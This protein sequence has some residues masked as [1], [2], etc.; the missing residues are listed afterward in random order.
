MSTRYKVLITGAGGM[1]GVD[2]SCELVRCYELYG[3]DVRRV[4]S[5]EYR[6]Q[7][8][9]SCDIIDRK[10]L[11]KLIGKIRPDV[12]IH[13]AAQTDVD[14]CELEPKKA[15][16]INS[17]GTKNVALACK[18]YG[19]VLIYISTDF[20]FD[21]KKRTPYKETDKPNPIS[22]Y[23]DSKLKGEEAVRKALKKFFILRTSW[24]YGKCGKN[25]VD[26]ILANAKSG[27]PLRVVDDQVGS[28][29]YTKDLA[30]AIH[31]LLNKIR[32]Q[33]T[34]YRE[35]RCGIYHISN[36]GIVSWYDYARGILK[37]VKSPA[38]IV[39]ISSEEL[40]RPARRPAMSVLDNSK[41]ERSTRFKMRN[42]KSALKEYLSRER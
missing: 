19:A 7:R 33:R 41:F 2:L 27:K 28:P 10:A 23:G 14:G 25:F 21:G 9:Y 6:V 12:V 15:Y 5:T 42:W 20:V 35:Q 26:T 38:K 31:L 1:L 36:S 37:L 30:K 16:R 29:T 22:V 11:E 13:A 32:V 40:D 39:P 3:I 17:E 4:Q 18:E 8:Y 34:E 24:L